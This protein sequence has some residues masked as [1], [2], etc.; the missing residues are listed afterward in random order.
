[1]ETASRLLLSLV[2][3]YTISLP[4]LG[5]YFPQ[6]LSS[7]N[8]ELQL[9]PYTSVGLVQSKFGKSWYAGSGAVTS[10]P[11]LIYSCAHLFADVG[12]WASQVNFARNYSARKKPAKKQIVTTRGYR[13]L[14]GYSPNYYDYQFEQDFAILYG[15]L[16][17]NFGP[18]LGKHPLLHKSLTSDG[19]KLVLGYPA[20]RDFDYAPGFHYLHRTGPFPLAFGNMWETYY[21]VKGVSTGPG[22]SGGPV[23][24]QEDNKYNLSGILV[25]GAYNLAGAFG[26]NS[27][28]ESSELSILGEIRKGTPT[29]VSRTTPLN[30]KDGVKSYSRINYPISGRTAVGGVLLD[31]AI[32]TTDRNQIDAY[33]RSPA[34][35]TKVVAKRSVGTG[36]AGLNLI[37]EDVTA[38]FLFTKAPGTWSLFARDSV[39]GGVSRIDHSALEVHTLWLK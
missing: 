21:E 15:G 17:T 6:P 25:S 28:S 11:R 23:L 7:Q 12:I 19:N 36:A 4:A 1:M 30:L 27:E 8:P 5:Q 3:L 39:K 2:F 18:P 24:V 33:L 10:D 31:L 9:A 34:G 22:N 14:S 16:N 35:R 13:I 26:L 38:P 20:Y 37:N 32:S 29:R